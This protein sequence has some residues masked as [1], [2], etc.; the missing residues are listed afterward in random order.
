MTLSVHLCCIINGLYSSVAERQSCKLKVLGSI[1]SGGLCQPHA[2]KCLGGS[3]ATQCAG[4]SCEHCKPRARP[5]VRAW[6]VLL[7]PP[8]PLGFVCAGQHHA[9]QSVWG[10]ILLASSVRCRFLQALG[11]GSKAHGSGDL[12]R[13][14]YD[15][16][17]PAGYRTDDLKLSTCARLAH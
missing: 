4:G 5:P 6:L 8:M 3:A 17:D 16:R 1:P 12:V 11:M 2:G 15:A 13:K 14:P 9:H 10:P 7:F